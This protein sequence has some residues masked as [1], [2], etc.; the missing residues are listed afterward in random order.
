[1]GQIEKLIKCGEDD[2]ETVD[3]IPSP[4]SIPFGG[5]MDFFRLGALP[6]ITPLLV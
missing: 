5:N 3:G 6:P 1:M 2:T 4:P